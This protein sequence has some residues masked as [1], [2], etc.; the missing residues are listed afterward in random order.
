MLDILD[1]LSVQMASGSARLGPV[2]SDSWM[3]R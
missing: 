3:V 2:I 1:T